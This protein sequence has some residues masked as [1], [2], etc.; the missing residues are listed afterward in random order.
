LK[1]TKKSNNINNDQDQKQKLH[2]IWDNEEL[3]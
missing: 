2:F 3:R 1:T